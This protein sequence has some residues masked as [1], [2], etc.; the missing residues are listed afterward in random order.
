[1]SLPL[2][3]RSDQDEVATQVYVRG[4]RSIVIVTRVSFTTPATCRAKSCICNKYVPSLL[5]NTPCA[6]NFP[7]VFI[8]TC[9]SNVIPCHAIPCYTITY[10]TRSCIISQHVNVIQPNISPQEFPTRSIPSHSM[11]SEYTYDKAAIH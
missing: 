6:I 10:H 7:P 2:E 5:S 11:S 4:I 8:C 1:M 3:S 9:A